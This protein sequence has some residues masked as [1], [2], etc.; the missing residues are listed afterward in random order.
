MKWDGDGDGGWGLEIEGGKP[1]SLVALLVQPHC[2]AFYFPERK[3][4]R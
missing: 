3:R 1:L 2:K 4:F